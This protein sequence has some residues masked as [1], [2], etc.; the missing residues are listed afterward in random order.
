M[1]SEQDENSKKELQ[2]FRNT[3]ESLQAKL[4]TTNQEKE[5]AKLF[6]TDLLYTLNARGY[7]TVTNHHGEVI[8]LYRCRGEH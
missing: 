2:R 5:E 7:E 4:V 1:E 3:I 6:L 8:D